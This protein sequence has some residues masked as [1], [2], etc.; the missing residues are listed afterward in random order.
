[1]YTPGDIVSPYHHSKWELRVVEVWA[2]KA[3]V[4]GQYQMFAPS[5]AVAVQMVK[6]CPT[7]E[8]EHDFPIGWEMTAPESE[9]N[10]VERKKEEW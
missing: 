4:S 7:P 9:F 5:H 1:M 3:Y 8:Q 6:A 2:G 10:L